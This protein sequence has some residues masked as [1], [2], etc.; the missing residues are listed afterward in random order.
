MPKTKYSVREL[1]D[2]LDN[3]HEY[4]SDY[5]NAV[6]PL[7]WDLEGIISLQQ[8][9]HG[10]FEPVTFLDSARCSVAVVV[11][12]VWVLEVVWLDVLVVLCLGHVVVRRQERSNSRPGGGKRETSSDPEPWQRDTRI[13]QV[14][15]EPPRTS[16]LEVHH[17]R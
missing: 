3:I 8:P 17:G 16:T 4:L 14:F 2:R 10:R 15:P 12:V 7:L 6:N 9:A 5:Y 13:G 1:L 11:V